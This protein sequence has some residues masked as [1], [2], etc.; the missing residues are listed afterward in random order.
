MTKLS[1]KIFYPVL[2]GILTAVT[3]FYIIPRFFMRRLED[4]L[5]MMLMALI[6]AV[7]SV[8]LQHFTGKIPPRSVF[9][10]LFTEVLIA[11]IFYKQI[12]TFLGYKL[13]SFEWD[14]IEF[15]QYYMFTSGCAFAATASQ[16][17]SLWIIR[18]VKK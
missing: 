11:V 1:R 9:L 15:I 8:L 16:F 13:V 10:S 17:V 5:W 14:L 7:I 12:G 6:P 18:K 4:F 2:C 3:D